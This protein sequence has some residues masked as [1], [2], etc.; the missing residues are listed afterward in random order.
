MIPIDS[1]LT[2]FVQSVTLLLG[3]LVFVKNPKD[4]VN[5]TFAILILSGLLWVFLVFLADLTKDYQIALF[6]TK[7]AMAG[8]ILIGPLFY[9]FSLIFPK[10]K[11]ISFTKK[12]FILASVLLLFF[13]SSTSLNVERIEIRDWGA[14]FTPGPLYYFIVFYLILYTGAAFKEFRTT[15][16][17]AEEGSLERFQIRYILMALIGS[18]TIGVLLNLILPSLGSAQSSKYGPSFSILFFTSLTA[19]TVLKYHL[20]NIKVIMTEALVFLLIGILMANISVSKNLTELVFNALI[21]ILTT[22]VGVA[23]IRSVIQEINKREQIEKMSGELKIAYQELKKLDESKSEF[24]SIASHQLRTPLSTV[25]GYIS[26]IL[27]G[28]YGEIAK[29][30][31]LPLERVYDANEKLIKLVN[32]LLDVSKIEAGKIELEKQSLFVEELIEEATQVLKISVE[33]KNLYL[34]FERPTSPLPKVFLDKEKFSQAILNIIDN[35]I[36]YTE[37]GGITISAEKGFGIPGK[38]IIK[39]KDTG[40]GMEKEELDHLFESFSRGTAGSKHWTEGA[41]LGLYVA[42]K[43]ITIHNGKVWAESEGDGKGSTF[44]IEIPVAEK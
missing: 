16:F 24:V 9:Y 21:L 8:P 14:D 6:W 29:R 37:K 41:G 25:K 22:I 13:L 7:A 40:I 35:A 42:K 43:F 44:Y 34:R 26:M 28:T 30:T 4:R 20:L 1:A 10:Y 39:I 23:L 36:R 32:N 33:K 31:K 3:F 27:E 12:L 5:Q 18:L 17:K 2:V 38:V 11:P 15:Y 19:I